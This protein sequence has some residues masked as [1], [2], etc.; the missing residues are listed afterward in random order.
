MKTR[1]VN[2]KTK[3]SPV[4]WGIKKEYSFLIILLLAT[5]MIRFYST[6]ELSGGDDSEFAELAM[7]SLNSENKIQSLF[8]PKIPNEPISWSG[9][10]YPRPFSIIPIILTTLMIGYSKYAVALPSVLFSVLSALMLYILIKKQFGKNIAIT[11]IILFVFN[12]FHVNFTRSGFLHSQLLFLDIL[13]IYLIV[14]GVEENNNKMFYYSIIP[15]LFNLWT[16]EF[17]GLVPLIGLIPYV[18]LKRVKLQQYKH[19]IYSG[20][21]GVAIFGIYLA[22]P[23]IISSDTSFIMKIVGSFFHGIGQKSGYIHYIG[24]GESFKL[25]NSYLFITPFL[26]LL[27]VPMVFGLIYSLLNIKKPEYILWL[28]YLFSSILFYIQGQPYIQRLVVYVPA[29]VLF[30]SIGIWTSYKSYLS[31]KKDIIFPLLVIITVIYLFLVIKLFPILIPEYSTLL[32]QGILNLLSNKIMIII[33]LILLILG[34]ILYKFSKSNIF[35]LNIDREKL[36][37]NIIVCFMIMNIVV[38]SILVIGNI[39]TFKRDAPITKIANYLNFDQSEK[40]YNCVSFTHDK[41]FMYYT[42]RLCAN[43]RY[44]DSIWLEEQKS[45]GELKYFIVNLY[46]QNVGVGNK[47]TYGDL[48]KY[49]PDSKQWLEKNSIEITTKI[50]LDANNPYFKI[51]ELIE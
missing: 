1:K 13:F 17:R 43:W 44:V 24:F 38:C 27:F 26:G 2:H 40:K 35:K 29:Y 16:T 28:T 48:E 42:Q 12:P 4:F 5:F 6:N 46:Q 14:K 36:A 41:S 23:A 50:G 33:I 30:A 7:F 18:L 25:M 15:L 45:K 34:Y 20:I 49:N 21:I 37:K 9:V 51:Y 47:E 31:N 8:Y 32:P 3:K 11:S 10:S 19:M 22:I 39:G